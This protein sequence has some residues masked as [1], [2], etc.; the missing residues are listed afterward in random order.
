MPITG[1]PNRDESAMAAVYVDL[2]GDK[3]T[4]AQWTAH[5]TAHLDGVDLE[6]VIEPAR[7]RAAILLT[8]SDGSDSGALERAVDLIVSDPRRFG[9]V[10][11][12]HTRR[13]T[14]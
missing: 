4:A 3:R 14:N 9:L 5:L 2:P 12:A 11:A 13:A 8:A 1:N 6:V 10:D 7:A